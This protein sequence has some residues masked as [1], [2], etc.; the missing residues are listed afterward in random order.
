MRY[1]LQRSN[2]VTPAEEWQSKRVD[3][4]SGSHILP[5]EAGELWNP[6]HW[7]RLLVE[8]ETG[9]TIDAVQFTE[10][11]NMKVDDLAELAYRNLQLGEL[12]A[13]FFAR[14]K[15]F[16]EFVPERLKLAF[17]QLEEGCLTG[18]P[19]L[20]RLQEDGAVVG[21]PSKN[22][23]QNCKD[24]AI[25][26]STNC[27]Y[28]LNPPYIAFKIS[29]MV[30]GVFNIIIIPNVTFSSNSLKNLFGNDY[31]VEIN[32]ES[33]KFE[34]CPIDFSN[35]FRADGRL[36]ASF[37]DR[38]LAPFVQGVL[39]DSPVSWNN[40]PLPSA[41]EAKF[42]A[43]VKH[44][45]LFVRV[46]TNVQQQNIIPITRQFYSLVHAIKLLGIQTKGIT[47]II[48]VASSHELPAVSRVAIRQL[49]HII[50]NF[51]K[52]EVLV[53]TVNPDRLTR[54]HNE[55]SQ[56]LNKFKWLTSGLA[57]DTSSFVD[58]GEYK[59]K[60]C[61]QVAIGRN[62]ASQQGLYSRY[63]TMYCRILS[64]QT[65]TNSQIFV[66]PIGNLV[67]ICR[68]S[69]NFSNKSSSSIQTQRSLL[70][71]VVVGLKDIRAIEQGSAWSGES[72]KIILR[73]MDK[74][75]D[76]TYVCTSVDRVCRKI[77]DYQVL[78]E[79]LTENRNRLLVLF[80]PSHVVK[81][82][83]EAGIQPDEAL[84]HDGSIVDQSY[85]HT[86][87]KLAKINPSFFPLY[88]GIKKGILTECI[89]TCISD[90]S[91]FIEGFKTSS[92]QGTPGSLPKELK[93]ELSNK[94]RG[95]QIQHIERFSQYLEIVF[96][97]TQSKINFFD[98]RVCKAYC[99]C[100]LS[101]RYHDNESC[102][103]SCN[104]C[105]MR[106]ESVCPFNCLNRCKCPPY[107]PCACFH[108]HISGS[109]NNERE[110]NKL[111]VERE[112]NSFFG[113]QFN[114]DSLFQLSSPLGA[115]GD[116]PCLNPQCEGIRQSQKKWCG[117]RCYRS[118]PTVDHDYMCN[119]EDCNNDVVPGGGLK[120]NTCLV[121]ERKRRKV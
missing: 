86:I 100:T 96:P 78:S 71:T 15:L 116:N 106:R 49:A 14:W 110:V 21:I 11:S 117:L 35:L 17:N 59:D 115:R 92:Y 113:N 23:F 99:Y 7:P 48:E 24:N 46:S 111:Y 18:W 103:C 98:S 20:S 54:R 16:G 50:S 120:C 58:I 65:S 105:C 107:C 61:E 33:V 10:K 34:D 38:V 9:E 64:G 52:N 85:L 102:V 104:F 53:L 40:V 77:E 56:F 121:K 2:N 22:T 62:A 67:G 19:L 73:W 42:C 30:A 26:I 109:R 118:D 1:H 114:L 80:W 82:A 72:L 108:C 28:F 81:V 4:K 84:Y 44:L 119:N 76:T 41:P 94:T 87:V 74:V 70:E 51:S 6:R 83:L 60:A 12:D 31:S 32:L 3:R 89:E 112:V 79:A 68:T 45:V 57:N 5:K 93:V 88:I 101:H 13:N 95:L 47:A 69:P 8:T 25:W 55:V 75:F 37:L 66:K 43:E 91:N 63:H 90:A 39:Y 29:R 36:N 97:E 27:F